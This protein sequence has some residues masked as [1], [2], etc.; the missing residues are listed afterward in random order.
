[1]FFG[2]LDEI[3]LVLWRLIEEDEH[4]FTKFCFD[5]YNMILVLRTAGKYAGGEANEA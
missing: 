5:G 4:H 2:E 3:C 1:M